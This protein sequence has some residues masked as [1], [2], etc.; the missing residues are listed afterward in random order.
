MA[1]DGEE[2]EPVDQGKTQRSDRA[3]RLS[4]YE[5]RW[6]DEQPMLEQRGYALR[7]RYRAG[8]SPSWL[9]DPSLKRRDCEDAIVPPV[10][11]P[12]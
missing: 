3:A 4:D 10:R 12:Q 1:A 9:K 8:W 11:Y 7:A 2:S 5:M 6:R